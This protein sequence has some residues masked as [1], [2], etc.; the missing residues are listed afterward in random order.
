MLEKIA[1]LPVAVQIV[2]VI[3]FSVAWCI[4]TAIVCNAVKDCFATYY[5]KFP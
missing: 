3:S 2:S 5:Q 4:C 1:V